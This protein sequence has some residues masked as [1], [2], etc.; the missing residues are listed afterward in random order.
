M[1]DEGTD[2]E[3]AMSALGA[4]WKSRRQVQ[5]QVAQFRRACK[6]LGVIIERQCRAAL[7]ATGLHDI[8]DETGDGDWQVVWERVAELGADLAKA[9]ARIAELEA[10]QKP[11]GYAVAVYPG[12]NLPPLIE[13][14]HPTLESAE[15]EAAELRK[16]DSS[17]VD[18]RVYGLREVNNRA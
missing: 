16:I 17:A 9:R 12:A 15:G 5:E 8:I 6:T 13:D 7:D 14:V 3:A 18:R 1:R 11:I 4:V 2:F 10:R